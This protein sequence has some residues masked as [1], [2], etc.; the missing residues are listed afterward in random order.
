[1]KLKMQL[2]RAGLAVAR[3]LGTTI[4]DQRTGSPVGKAFAFAWRGKIHIIGLETAVR[5][6]FLPQERMTY[7]QQ[8]LGFAT[9]PPP[10]YPNERASS[11]P[12]RDRETGRPG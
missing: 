10:D 1:M 11:V 9:H 4:I 6:F 7:W 12:V 5:P 8:E 3:A 2:R